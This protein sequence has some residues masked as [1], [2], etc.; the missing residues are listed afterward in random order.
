MTRDFD[1]A[2]DCEAVVQGN[3]PCRCNCELS[4]NNL[5]DAPA[6]LPMHFC[7]PFCEQDWIARSTAA[8]P[9]R[10][11]PDEAG[12][13]RINHGVGFVRIHKGAGNDHETRCW[14][15]T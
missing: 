2:F 14:Q 7:N 12:A 10:Q 11:A 4:F 15:A 6:N 1:T 5:E 9:A 13:R 8:K 3:G